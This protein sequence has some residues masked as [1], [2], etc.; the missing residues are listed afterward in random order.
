MGNELLQ[1]ECSRNSKPGVG[2]TARALLHNVRYE[3]SKLRALMSAVV[4][5]VDIMKLILLSL[6][7]ESRF[8]GLT[9]YNC[10]KFK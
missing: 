8:L 2:N 10:E 3:P 9:Y 4:D 5:L 6:D 7:Y 1:Q